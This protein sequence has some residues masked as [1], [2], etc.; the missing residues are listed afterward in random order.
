MRH[1]LVRRCTVPVF[2]VR[3]EPHDIAR[4]D[5]L[6]FFAFSLDETIPTRHNKSLTK[7]VGVPCVR[8]PGSNV[9]L[10]AAALAP[11]CGSNRGSIRAWPVKYSSGPVTEACVQSLV[12][13]IDDTHSL[14]GRLSTCVRCYPKR[15]FKYHVASSELTGN[16]QESTGINRNRQLSWWK[17]P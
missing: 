8:A 17:N 3:W 15:V 2:L 7:R 4:P 14:V 13:S 1:R 6:D 10:A 12:M 9:T 16:Q 5:V 11:S